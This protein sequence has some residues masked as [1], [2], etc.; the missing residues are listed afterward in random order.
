MAAGLP[1]HQTTEQPWPAPGPPGGRAADPRGT[2][3]RGA[4]FRGTDLRASDA[5]REVALAELGDNYVAG[6]LSHDTFVFRV[7]AVLR[8]RHRRELDHQVAD[9]PG[10]PRRRGALERAGERA[11]MLHR[12]F[13]REMGAALRSA[14]DAWTR[15]RAP[16]PVLPLPGGSRPRYTIGRELACDMSIGD[17]TV[18]RWHADLR[19]GPSG[20][21]L[22]DLGSTNGTRLNG[23]RITGPV[24]V[25]PGDLVSFGTATF[26]LGLASGA[27]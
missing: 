23:W 10:P 17:R 3:L 2:D 9:L 1:G 19:L 6:R 21:R 11:R 27:S 26:V 18:S 14:A 16:L 20:W 13:T 7:E 25:R 15:P 22:A 8:A 24:H 4:D 5:E 12:E